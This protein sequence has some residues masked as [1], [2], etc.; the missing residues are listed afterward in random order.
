[1]FLTTVAS[2]ACCSEVSQMKRKAYF[3]DEDTKETLRIPQTLDLEE[4][5]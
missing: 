4:G 3:H 2:V 1:M 5:E